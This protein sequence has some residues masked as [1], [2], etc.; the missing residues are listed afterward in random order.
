MRHD[1]AALERSLFGLRR[2]EHAR[3]RTIRIKASNAL[4]VDDVAA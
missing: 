1:V 3:R 2:M 4:G